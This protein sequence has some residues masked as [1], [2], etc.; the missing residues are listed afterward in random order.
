M[1]FRDVRPDVGEDKDGRERRAIGERGEE[2][3]MVVLVLMTVVRG[4][5][6][7]FDLMVRKRRK[8]DK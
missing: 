5:L 8:R 1:F 7:V 6:R 3:V 4:S 2:A